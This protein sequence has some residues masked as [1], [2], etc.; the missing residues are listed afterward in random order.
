MKSRI[1][2]TGLILSVSANVYAD[3]AQ[4]IQKGKDSA[5]SYLEKFANPEAIQKLIVNPMISTGQLETTNGEKKFSA[6]MTCGA[7][8]PFLAVTLGITGSGEITF[9]DIK[10]D[11][12]GDGVFDQTSTFPAASGI[13]SNGVIQCTPGTWDNCFGYKWILDDSQNLALAPS[14][15][16]ELGDCRCINNSCT[17]Q[18]ATMY[19]STLQQQIGATL[20]QVTSQRDY[21]LAITNVITTGQTL[22]YY[23]QAIASCGSSPSAVATHYY[24]NSSN[25]VQDANL[26]I[27][28]GDNKESDLRRL[29]MNSPTATNS[30]TNLSRRSC[31]ITRELSLDEISLLDV[32]AVGSGTASAAVVDSNTVDITIGRIG[33]NYYNPPGNCGTFSESAELAILR[34]DR[35]TSAALKHVIYDDHIQVLMSGSVIWNGPH[36]NWTNPNSPIPPTG[37][38]EHGRSNEE[39]D[40]AANLAVDL[41]PYMPA[42]PGNLSVG[43]N[44]RVGGR[45]EG[46]ARIRVTADTSCK[47]ASD[48]IIDDCGSLSQQGSCKLVEENIDGIQTILNGVRTGNATHPQSSIVSSTTCS[49][50][51]KRN[52]L[53]I[54]RTYEC[55]TQNQYDFETAAQRVSVIESSTTETSY[56]DLRT[57]PNSTTPIQINGELTLFDEIEVPACTLRCKVTKSEAENDVL[58]SGVSNDYVTEPEQSEIIYHE[59]KNNT[60]PIKQGEQI[61][62]DCGC[63]NGFADTAVM[64]QTIRMAGSDLLCSSGQKKL[65]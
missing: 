1:I 35:I 9:P 14:P 60:C 40:E 11:K 49:L 63:L 17:S 62:Q 47:E 15:L 19:F 8:T 13:C 33:N 3:A 2:I 25:L 6:P 31:E 16:T 64:M 46:Y 52:W 48:Q 29:V 28:T 58:V 39:N 20:S 5:N 37:N 44:V 26:K 30:L 56:T 59:C 41:I 32:I 21:S 24:K 34:P 43:L 27:S 4:Q 7:E 55:E 38:C 36:G 54:I 42:S 53:K 12:T 61:L 10:V 57:T 45:G 51:F 23:G 18:Y 22:T 65:P 50:N